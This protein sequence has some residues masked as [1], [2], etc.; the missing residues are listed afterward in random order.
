MNKSKER[1]YIDRIEVPGAS[2][3]YR[4][5]SRV[6]FV[7]P[8]LGPV[9]LVDISKSALR[10]ESELLFSKNTRLQLKICFPGKPAVFVKGKVSAIDRGSGQSVIQLLPF[11]YGT[12]YNSFYSKTNLEMLLAG[13]SDSDLP[14]PVSETHK[15]NALLSMLTRFMTS[16]Q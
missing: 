12:D 4:R 6:N 3:F 5:N 2:V 15:R 16:F 1:R 13:N 11:G 9:R 7:L 14:L 8:F 10:V